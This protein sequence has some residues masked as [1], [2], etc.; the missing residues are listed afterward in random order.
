MDG[1]ALTYF[2]ATHGKTILCK[3]RLRMYSGLF[4]IPNT[5][6]YMPFSAQD[7]NT[8][9]RQDKTLMTPS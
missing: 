1:T 9:A 8:A 6:I 7:Y 2:H 4:R 5:L 3:I